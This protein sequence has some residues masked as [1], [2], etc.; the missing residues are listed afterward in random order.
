MSPTASPNDWSGISLAQGRYLVR[1]KLGEGGMGYVYRALDNNL[2]MD[3][4]V[5][6]PR[7]SMLD[8]P[9]FAGRFSREVRSLVK[10]AHPNVV[11][12]T[13]VGE[14]DGVPYAVMQYLS[15]GSLEDVK[16]SAVAS[17]SA[18]LAALR[19]WL[20]GIA[21]A[22]DFVHGKGFVHRDV[23]PGNILFDAQGHAFL[24]DFGVAKAVADG[25][26]PRSA[27]RTAMT[28]AGFVLGTPE[29][30]AP[31]LVMGQA[32]DGR[33]DQYALAITVF[34]MLTGRRPFESTQSTAIL[35]MQTTQ[36]PP[37]LSRL[38]P[39]VPGA[40]SLAVERALAKDPSARFPSCTAFTSAV[41]R[42]VGESPLAAE[43]T[44]TP[45]GRILR[46]DQARRDCPVCGKGLVFAAALLDDRASLKGR[47]I[48]CPG[49]SSRLRF[50]DDGGLQLADPTASGSK[51]AP[52][53]PTQ[54]LVAQSSGT[55]PVARPPLSAMNAGPARTVAMAPPALVKPGSPVI[56]A[57]P[58]PPPS[59]RPKPP[60][61]LVLAGVGTGL[62]LMMGTAFVFL[63]HR[64][65]AVVATASV[66][67]VVREGSPAPLPIEASSPQPGDRRHAAGTVAIDPR[68]VPGAASIRLDGSEVTRSS[69]AGS[70]TLPVG[71]HEL[72]VSCEGFLPYRRKF[73]VSAD[74]ATALKIELISSPLPSPPPP[75]A[76][77]PSNASFASRTV[78]PTDL[79]AP[80]LSARTSSPG[81]F[82][83]VPPGPPLENQALAA[84]LAEPAGF[85]NR[86][87]VP[88]GLY[89][90]GRFAR[91]N[92][93][94]T[95]T[96]QVARVSYHV[97][98]RNPAIVQQAEDVLSV[99]L[100]RDFAERLAN[101][102]VIQIRPGESTPTGSFAQ[103]FN[104]TGA[105]LTLEV[106]KR[107]FSEREEWVAVVKEAEFLLGMNFRRIGEKKFKDSFHTITITSAGPVRKG[108]SPRSDWSSRLNA[109]YLMEIRH[110]ISAFKAN[111]FAADM[112]KLDGAM[113]QALGNLIRNS[114]D[115]ARAL[116]QRLRNGGR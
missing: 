68:E 78:V 14:Y 31:E 112:H 80:N 49:C 56:T 16:A 57:S 43:A 102:R 6:A 92:P 29:Y 83:P 74:R 8:D 34:E 15:G 71:T 22:L 32:F 87:V 36:T 90:F 96:A 98:A 11:K 51:R 12:V 1:A 35:V 48:A 97:Q 4:V 19:D 27:G 25:G 18:R 21:A 39:E 41:V 23:K 61:R 89:V 64:P 10:L 47:R 53:D 73:L 70:R 24:S 110:V 66:K 33:I 17:L 9:E 60:L 93:D 113:N 111:Q 65:G 107:Q 38:V 30:M 101:A 72:T 13:D 3:V 116:D 100:D 85:S 55:V 50:H 42:A 108:I 76:V 75:V 114:S 69:L 40:L 2:D 104:D 5:K 63:S 59:S 20:P 58:P 37:T 79:L 99:L 26:D 91:K 67:T 81:L 86:V 94:E 54:R 103:D 95:V 77:G 105:V 45:S 46:P 115:P 62:I 84:V 88:L 44:K 82:E 109:K 7:R 52:V 106:A 28:G